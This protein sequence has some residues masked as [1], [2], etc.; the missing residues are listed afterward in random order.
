MRYADGG[1]LRTCLRPQREDMLAT[2]HLPTN[3][4]SLAVADVVDGGL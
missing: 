3:T 2:R 1:S 4:A